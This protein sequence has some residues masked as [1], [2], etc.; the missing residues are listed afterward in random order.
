MPPEESIEAL[1][2]REFSDEVLLTLALTHSS[3]INENPKSALES[4]ERLEFLG[5]SVL[6]FIIAD[7]LYAQ[8]PRLTEGEMTALRAQLVSSRALASV[9][10][11]MGLGRFLRMGQ[12]EEKSG[13]R[14][15]ERILAGALEAVIGAIWLDAGLEAARDFIIGR[16]NS[17]IYA[18]LGGGSNKSD[19]NYKSQLQEITQATLQTLPRYETVEQLS[20]SGSPMF[21]AKVIVAGKTLGQ[22]EGSSKKEAQREAARKA[23]EQ[24]P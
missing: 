12:G 11:E 22:G 16:L 20:E 1:I 4:N 5:D 21:A 8:W 15:K 23:L 7:D 3:C 10:K 24:F 9:A 6:G 2:G 19:Y 17:R 14:D 13:G 18:A